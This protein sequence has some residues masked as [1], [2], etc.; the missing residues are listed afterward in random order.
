M[1]ILHVHSGNIFGGVERIL[2]AL[3][4]H[5][6]HSPQFEHLFALCFPDRLAAELRALS[7]DV[8]FLPE[9]HLSRFWEILQARC[10]LGKLLTKIKP[11]LAVVHS[12]WSHSAFAPVIHGAGIPL[13]FWLHTKAT[14]RA[15]LEK[16]AQLHFPT[17]VLSVSH[18]VDSTAHLLFPGVPSSVVHSPLALDAAAFKR[19][20][21]ELTRAALGAKPENVVILQA[22]RLEPWKGHRQLIAALRLLRDNPRWVCW[23]AGGASTS[24]EINYL[25]EIRLEASELGSR[26]HF[27]GSR[28]DIP[29]LL[30]AAD[31]YCQP[32]LEGE[33]FSIA[34]MEAFFA[35][36]PIVTSAL[37]G[38]TEIVDSASGFLLQ[39]GD[40]HVLARSLQTLIE[41]E[42]LRRQL[43]ATGRRRVMERCDPTKQFRE[44]ESV[45]LKTVASHV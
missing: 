36:L 27:L 9:V 5:K 25:S 33:G 43:G 34:F 3:A 28:S 19:A 32:N 8:H 40:I 7:A 13:L 11:D 21:R 18:A 22:S 2:L 45:F 31:I 26:V 35:N 1:R 29:E 14:G 15:P 16:W 30:T 44:L 38:A 4:D 42:S 39:P 6:K 20:N 17:R 24:D 12:T 41:N 10:A 37:G 23:I